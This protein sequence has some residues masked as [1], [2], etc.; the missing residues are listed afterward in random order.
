MPLSRK[1]P[2]GNS[3]TAAIDCCDFV[4]RWLFPSGI[5]ATNRGFQSNVPA[6]SERMSCQSHIA[7]LVAEATY[8]SGRRIKNW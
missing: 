8:G 2:P 5:R 6:F 7:R 4:H 3:A 1:I